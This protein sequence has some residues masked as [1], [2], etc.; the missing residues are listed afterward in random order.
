[1]TKQRDQLQSH[2]TNDIQNRI[3]FLTE[4][5]FIDDNNIPNRAGNISRM[6][7]EIPGLLIGKLLDQTDFLDS[8]RSIDM[9]VLFSM[10]NNVRITDENKQHSASHMQPYV[11]S[12]VELMEN[13]NHE[14]LSL[15]LNYQL[16]PYED[17]YNYDIMEYIYLWCQNENETEC[18]ALITKMRHES[19]IFLG[20]FVKAII[21]INNIVEEL[22]KVGEH[23]QNMEFLNKLTPIS[24]M[25]LKFVATNQSLYV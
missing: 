5:G 10:F 25:L 15:G 8:L 6:C 20:D 19:E 12:I 3:A 18:M 21:K 24:G 16:V 1:M 2:F 11:S 17:E 7:Q 4:A 9:I 13:I 14:I 22:K 23:F